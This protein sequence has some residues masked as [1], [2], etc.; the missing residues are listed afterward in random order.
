M[1]TT[2]VPAQVTTV[3]DT[4][5]GNLTL[6]QVVLLVIA[7]LLVAVVTA[8]FPPVLQVRAYKIVLS[9]C[10]G[11]PCVLL[12]GRWRGQLLLTWMQMKLSY[13]SRPRL[14]LLSEHDY[15]HCHCLRQAP[16]EHKNRVNVLVSTPKALPVLKPHEQLELSGLIDGVGRLRFTSNAKGEI[17]VVLE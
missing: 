6:T 12:A 14:Y 2:I 3:E 1:K 5:A 8:G 11:L 9:L 13:R 7:V 10:L 16:Q 17:N 15:G 4:I